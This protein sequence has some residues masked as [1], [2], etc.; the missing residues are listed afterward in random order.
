MSGALEALEDVRR[1][2]RQV[3]VITLAVVIVVLAALAGG[4]LVVLSQSIGGQHDE[5]SVSDARIASLQRDIADLREEQGTLR[6][7]QDALTAQLVA[8]KITPVVTTSTTT[9]M[10]RPA[11]TTTV[12]ARASQGQP[13]STTSTTRPPTTTTTR[14][15]SVAAPVAGCLRR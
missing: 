5:R 3:Q 2:A 14:P 4:S 15:C 10:T 9:P 11:A 8:A 1:R 6:S 12:P 13:P 7:N